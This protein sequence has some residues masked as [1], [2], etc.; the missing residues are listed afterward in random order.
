MTWRS[1]RLTARKILCGTSPK[2][3]CCFLAGRLPALTSPSPAYTRVMDAAGIQMYAASEKEWVEKI[4]HYKFARE[5]ER[6]A[7]LKK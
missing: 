1:S 6:D 3:S 7:L 4:L 5:S 2:I